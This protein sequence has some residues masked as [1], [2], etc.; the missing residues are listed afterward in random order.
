MTPRDLE[1]NG[2]LPK[3]DGMIVRSLL[4]ELGRHIERGSFDG[5]KHESAGWH[6]ASES[7][8][9]KLD[10]AIST[11]QNVLGLGC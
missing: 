2:S 10:H 3:V 9:T 6:G 4:H 5:S 8:V 7:E 11:D 1:M